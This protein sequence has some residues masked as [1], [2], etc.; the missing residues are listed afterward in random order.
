MFVVNSKFRELSL[1]PGVS[2]YIPCKHYVGRGQ[3]ILRSDVLNNDIQMIFKI[4]VWTIGACYNYS[5]LLATI[6]KYFHLV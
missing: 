3:N 1:P 5:E 2:V 6:I 4:G